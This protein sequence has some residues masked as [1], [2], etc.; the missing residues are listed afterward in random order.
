M[1]KATAAAARLLSAVADSGV[2]TNPGAMTDAD[3]AR[4]VAAA[5]ELH[6]A[7]GGNSAAIS[8]AISDVADRAQR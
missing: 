8:V 2:L 5:H 6:A 1:S 7:T 3:I 4:T